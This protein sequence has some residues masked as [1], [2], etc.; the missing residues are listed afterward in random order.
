MTL[1]ARA[2]FALLFLIA[3]NFIAVHPTIAQSGAGTAQSI[4]QE[5]LVKLLK[6]LDEKGNEVSMDSGVATSL[7]IA[8]KGGVE[9]MKQLVYGVQNDLLL[10]CRLKNGELVFGHVAPDGRMQ[11]YRT[12]SDLRLL[13]AAKKETG[14]FPEKLPLPDAQKAL[15]KDFAIWREA[16]NTLK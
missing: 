10:L 16:A 4:P 5:Q 14:K 11:L 12:A 6:F 13:G 15:Q 8:I 2:A 3:S 7:G 1:H 9:K